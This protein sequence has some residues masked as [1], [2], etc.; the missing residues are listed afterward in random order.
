MFTNEK[1]RTYVILNFKTEAVQFAE[2]NNKTQIRSLNFKS[3]QN[4]NQQTFQMLKCFKVF[5]QICIH[6]EKI[7][8]LSD[9]RKHILLIKMDREKQF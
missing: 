7:F 5:P 3:R 4:N 6:Y 9:K 2:E 1:S 8:G